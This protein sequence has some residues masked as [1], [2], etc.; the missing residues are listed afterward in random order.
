[1]G[2]RVLISVP[3]SFCG[4]EQWMSVQCTDGEVP[5]I[6]EAELP[7]PADSIVST[8]TASSKRSS[9]SKSVVSPYIKSPGGVGE[10]LC[11]STPKALRGNE[12]DSLAQ[13]EPSTG[14][15][16]NKKTPRK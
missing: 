11:R 13:A 12:L 10:R 3:S 9:G 7:D 15:P 6:P 1:M 5:I 14:E 4:L 16:A 8:P 2:L